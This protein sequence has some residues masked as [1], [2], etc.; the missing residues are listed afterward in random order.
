MFSRLAQSIT[1]ATLFASALCVPV[2]YSAPPSD[3][4]PNPSTA[5]LATIEQL[6]QG[7]LPNGG[8]PPPGSV[9]AEGIKNFQ[10]INFNENF[11]VAFF[12]SLVYNITEN[13]SGFQIADQRERDFV[14]KSLNAAVA[15]S[16]IQMPF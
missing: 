10:L 6:A 15:V 8:P 9:N 14:L 12:K 4:F 13:V 7:T 3:G 2:Q 5:Q 11:E 1:A 16:R